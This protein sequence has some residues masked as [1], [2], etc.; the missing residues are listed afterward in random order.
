MNAK[1][2]N[3]QIW[4]GF[5]LSFFGGLSYPLFFVKFPITRDFPW[6]NLLLFGI[7]IVLLFIGVRRAF[8]PDRRR[9]SKI[10]ASVLATL[11]VTI[12]GLFIFSAFVMGRWLPSSQAAPKIGEKAPDFRLADTNGK[13]VTLSEL[14]SAPIEG[15]SAPAN[16]KGVLL[17][18]Y[19]GYW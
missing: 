6:A 17:I 7:A 3:W 9:R 16:P 4:A 14:L 19:R 15:T 10:A 13:Q 18:F 11:G 8:A 5:L 1:K 2:F 12:I